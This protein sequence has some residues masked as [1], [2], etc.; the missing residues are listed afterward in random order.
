[1]E[2]ILEYIPKLVVLAIVLV[3]VFVYL[4]KRLTV[5]WEK[6]TGKIHFLSHKWVFVS[7]IFC[8]FIFFGLP[9]G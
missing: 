2:E 8:G 9:Y 6:K 3:I 1:M 5:K 7:M 4:L